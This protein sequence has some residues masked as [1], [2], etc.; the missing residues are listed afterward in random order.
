MSKYWIQR[1]NFSDHTGMITGFD[2]LIEYDYMGRSEFEF[3]SLNR[4]LNR[5]TSKDLK[6]FSTQYKSNVNRGLF[7]ITDEQN[8]DRV[9]NS[10]LEDLI[11]G[12]D[13]AEPSYIWKSLND[14]QFG[15]VCPKLFG[16]FECWIDIHNDVIFCLG[17]KNAA[18]LIKG[19]TAYRNR[20]SSNGDNR[21]V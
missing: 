18:K 2:Q 15:K 19:I 11:L 5:M 12:K 13:E 10:I 8:I 7:I 3:G 6:I 9:K 17:K 20:N 16:R 1:A 21:D 14:D 4:F